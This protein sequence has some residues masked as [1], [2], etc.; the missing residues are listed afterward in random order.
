MLLISDTE[1]G[2]VAILN[3]VN[4]RVWFS[5]YL[6]C[7]FLFFELL[8]CVINFLNHTSS[9]LSCPLYS[10]YVHNVLSHLLIS[11]SLFFCHILLSNL[12]KRNFW[13]NVIC[14]LTWLFRED[15]ISKLISDSNKKSIVSW[16]LETINRGLGEMNSRSV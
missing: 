16:N 14:A 13:W 4:N 11:I 5:T 15:N 10:K 6:F 3:L 9:H 1:L 7:F 12:T 2:L 8:E